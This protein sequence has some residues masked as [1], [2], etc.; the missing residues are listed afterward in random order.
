M[1]IRHTEREILAISAPVRFSETQRFE[2]WGEGETPETDAIHEVLGSEVSERSGYQ[3]DGTNQ[4]RIRIIG[5][6][7]WRLWRRR[8]MAVETWTRMRWVLKKKG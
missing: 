4:E 2:R 6:G 8:L 3:R 5:A 1:V 7:S